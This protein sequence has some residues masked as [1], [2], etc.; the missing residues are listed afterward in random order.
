MNKTRLQSLTSSALTLRQSRDVAEAYLVVGPGNYTERRDPGKGHGI[1][2]RPHDARR[3]HQTGCASMLLVC[4]SV[5]TRTCRAL[6][7][8]FLYY[9]TGILKHEYCLSVDLWRKQGFQILSRLG[10][11]WE[12]LCISQRTV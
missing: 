12:A 3:R 1:D 9:L 7:H 4:F 8:V 5:A 2:P 6:H 10:I 11:V